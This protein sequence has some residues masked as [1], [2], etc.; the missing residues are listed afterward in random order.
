MTGE[1]H[2]QGADLIRKAFAV[3]RQSGSPEWRTMTIA[4]LKNRL[5][6]LTNREFKEADWGAT[7]FKEFVEQFGGVVTIDEADRPPRVTLRDEAALPVSGG[8]PAGARDIGPRRRI[9][10]DLWTAVLDYSGPWVYV[11]ENGYA[12]AVASE[13]VAP[14]ATVLPSLTKAEF[15]AW[16]TEFVERISAESSGADPFL[17]GWLERE[18]PLGVLPAEYRV[19][20]VIELKRRVLG[21]LEDWFRANDIPVPADLVVGDEEPAEEDR[22]EGAEALREYAL[23][24]IRGMTAAELE[25]LQ[26]PATAALRAKR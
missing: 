2:E 7:T 22:D 24:A 26:L 23:A 8:K 20:W 5:L 15:K 10:N 11:W 14:G 12:T 4:V 3:A 21:R 16:R 13:K 17:R 1:K 25:A 6:D 9:R 19:P 18:Q